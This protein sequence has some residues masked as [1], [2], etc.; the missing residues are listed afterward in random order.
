MPALLSTLALLV[1]QLPGVVTKP[2]GYMGLEDTLHSGWG[3]VSAPTP[4]REGEK[5]LLISQTSSL[6]GRGWERPWDLA[7]YSFP[8]LCAARKCPRSVLALLWGQLALPACFSAHAQRGCTASRSSCQS[9]WPDGAGRHSS[10]GVGLSQPPCLG[11][12]CCRLLSISQTSC[13]V[14]RGR[15][16]PW[17]LAVYRSPCCALLRKPPRSVLALFW[18][19]LALPLAAAPR[20]YT[21]SRNC[22]QSFCSNG[23]RRHS[24]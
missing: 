21:A 7:M 18:G 2:S 11:R 13:L 23:A 15:E 6:V 12:S 19:P 3:H 1:T 14:G 20:G 5:L 9:F 10:Q 4:A 24:P 22:C 16:L 17:D 8:C